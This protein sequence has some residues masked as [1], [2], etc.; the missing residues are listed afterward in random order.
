[1]KPFLQKEKVIER[2]TPMP[3]LKCTEC[4]NIA[5]MIYKGTT[6]CRECYDEKRRTGNI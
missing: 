5:E 2:E 4:P 1:M 6:Y 3:A